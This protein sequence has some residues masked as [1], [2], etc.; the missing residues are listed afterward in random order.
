MLTPIVSGDP[1]HPP[2]AAIV[3]KEKEWYDPQATVSGKAALSQARLSRLPPVCLLLTSRPSPACLP[4]SS[5]P[6]SIRCTQ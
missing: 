6:H 1:C 5:R 3:G 2:R 4:D